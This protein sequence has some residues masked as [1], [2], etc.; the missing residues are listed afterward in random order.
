[1]RSNFPLL[2]CP[3]KSYF[4]IFVIHDFMQNTI[5]EFHLYCWDHI[6]KVNEWCLVDCFHR[7]FRV[8]TYAIIVQSNLYKATTLGTT[9]KW[10]SWAGGRLIEHLYKMTTNQMW[11]FL[12]GFKFF[13]PTLIFARIKIS[14]CFGAIL[15]D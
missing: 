10:S 6:C 2:R 8:S 13:S 12:A 9:Q 14:N 7:E 5:R 3:R 1:M 15:E 4:T 11:S